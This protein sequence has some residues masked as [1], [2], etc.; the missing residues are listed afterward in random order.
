MKWNIEESVKIKETIG[1]KPELM[2]KLGRTVA[3]IFSKYE[4]KLNNTSYVFEPRI[5][6]MEPEEAPE[7]VIKSRKSMLIENVANFYN[8]KV[9][10]EYILWW[11]EKMRET[12]CLPQCGIPDPLTLKILEQY[13]ILENFSI[14]PDTD[15]STSE[16]LIRQIVGNKE[17]LMDL[18]DSIFPILNKEGWSFNGD[19]GCVL[20]PIVFETPIYAQKVSLSEELQPIRGFGPQIYASSATI[21]SVAKIKP[22]PGLLIIPELPPMP[23]VIIHR[24]WWIGIPSPEMLK[25]LDIMRETKGI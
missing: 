15:I 11:I 7:I 4:I 20:T 12:L 9:D 23:G 22:I 2:E 8:Y 24:W 13:R 16:I 1:K 6:T 14:K 19:R 18:S 3:D 21:S 10:P 17:L 25:A 5:F